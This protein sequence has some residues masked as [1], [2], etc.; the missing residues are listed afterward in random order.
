MRAG[1]KIFIALMIFILCACNDD[2][3]AEHTGHKVKTYKVAVP[4]REAQGI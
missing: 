4:R 3:S 2:F 1:S